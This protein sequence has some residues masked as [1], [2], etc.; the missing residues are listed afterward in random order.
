MGQSRGRHRYRIF[1]ASVPFQLL[2]EL[3][4]AVQKACYADAT[5]VYRP[6][7]DPEVLHGLVRD[8]RPVLSGCLREGDPAH[9]GDRGPGGVVSR[10][11]LVP[12]AEEG[13]SV[14]APSRIGALA[15]SSCAPLPSACPFPEGRMKHAGL[16]VPGCVHLIVE[17]AFDADNGVRESVEGHVAADMN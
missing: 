14:D 4:G 15:R 5:A 12:F 13:V 9:L 7:G 17:H 8:G 11:L 3:A 16:E 6:V 2:G 1:L 10:R